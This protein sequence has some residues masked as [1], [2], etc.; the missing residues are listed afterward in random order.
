MDLLINKTTF[1]YDHYH[2]RGKTT[3]SRLAEIEG[4]F[5]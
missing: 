3:E 5:S 2:I 1:S 4:I